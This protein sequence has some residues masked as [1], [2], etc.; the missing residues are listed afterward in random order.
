MGIQALKP[1][2]PGGGKWT[3]DENT[4]FVGNLPP[5]TTVQHL[6]SIFGGF[7]AIAPGGA[8]A[9]MDPNKQQC[10]GIAFINFLDP[11][12]SNLAIEALNDAQLP[13]GSKLIVKVKSPPNPKGKG[14]GKA[15][16]ALVDG[17]LGA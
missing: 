10:K 2:L 5:D 8:Y 4:L 14:K 7:G 11:T 16:P 13:W 1:Y 6:Y 15:A 17:Q 3:N 12:A 9:Q